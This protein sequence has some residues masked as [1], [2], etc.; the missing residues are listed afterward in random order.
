[1]RTPS[2]ALLLV[3]VGCGSSGVAPSPVDAGV[4]AAAPSP[5]GD[6]LT[7]S[8]VA[9]YQTVKVD[10]MKDGAPLG[11]Y[12][13]PLVTAKAGIFRV[14]VTLTP[15]KGWRSKPLEAELHLFAGGELIVTDKKTIATSSDD[16]LYGT[17]FNFHFDAKALGL[18]TSFHLIVRD[19]ALA[20][21]GPDV[22]EVRYPAAG[23]QQLAISANPGLV[24]I[25][26]VPV[27]YTADQSDRL[28]ATDTEELDG[29]RALLLDM[30]PAGTVDLQ[31][32]PQ[33]LVWSQPV[34]PSGDGW[35]TLLGGVID[36]RAQDA[37]GD[38]VYYVG[39][40]Q[41]RGSF[42]NY[43]QGGC[44]LG[45]APLAGPTDAFERGALVI[46]YPGSTYHGTVAHELGHTMGRSHAPCGGPQG[47]DPKFP[48]E[49]GTDGVTGYSISND[50]LMPAEDFDVMGYCQ[51]VWISDYTYAALFDRVRVVNYQAAMTGPRPMQ[52]F[53]RIYIGQDG[54]MREGGIVQRPFLEG[55]LTDVALSLPN[56]TKQHVTGHFFAY[57]HLAGGY[58]LVP[59]P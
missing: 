20:A 9:G 13:A 2:L 38:D 31:V 36:T 21:R 27:Q 8:E 41:P 40:F 39:A 42:G 24:K 44:V 43:C 45:L 51:P 15:K 34:D 46:G 19:P 10:V 3:V 53:R 4:E 28:P 54:V 18:S 50:T 11:K 47:I 23:Q 52:K 16:D 17:T 59:L 37:P 56:G 49:G 33:P 14:Y 25:V 26:V 35:D 58:V 32:R 5:L 30:Y 29:I 48:Y 6:L 22:A 12:N 57:D 1:M 7:I 55:P